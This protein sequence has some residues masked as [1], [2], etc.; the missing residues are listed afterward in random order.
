MSQSIIR[1]TVIICTA[2]LIVNSLSAQNQIYF[3]DSPLLLRQSIDLIQKEQ[4]GAALQKIERLKN[5]IS[6]QNSPFYADASYYEALCAVQL[7][8]KDAIEKVTEFASMHRSSSWMPRMNFLEGRVFFE[9]KRYNDALAAFTK[10]NLNALPE[11]EQVELEYKMAFCLL[12]QNQLKEAL[13]RF[14]KIKETK[15]PYQNASIYHYAH[16]QYLNSKDDDA[17]YHFQRIKNIS[18]FKKLVPLYELQ[19]NYR[20]GN[21][22]Q[23]MLKGNEV[24]QQVESKRKTEVLRMIADAYYKKDLF[25]KALSYYIQY[26]NQNKRQ[27][28]R[29]DNYQIGISRYKTG[30][31]KEAIQN[32][33]LVINESDALSQSASYHLAQCFLKNNQKPFAR[34]AFLAAHKATFDKQISEDAL[35]NY[36][37]LS[38][39][40][41]S[42]PFHDAAVLLEKYI[43]SRINTAR[44]NEAQQLI[45]QHYLHTNNFDAALSSLEKNKSRNHEM[46]SI[47]EQ[48]TY[49]LAIELYNQGNFAKATTYLKRLQ[50][51]NTN[52]PLHAN[53][54]FWLAESYYQQKNFVDAQTTY[55]QFIANRVAPKSEYFQL[56]TY[57]LGYTYFQLKQYSA[58]VPSFKQF[59]ANTYSKDPRLTFDAWM[60]IGDC[61]FI[62]KEFDKAIDAYEKVI[63]ARHADA[64]Y[65]LFQKGIAMGA[66]G[67]NNL[68]I[69]ALDQLIKNYPR[70]GFY[71]N[72]LFEMAT[73]NIIMND[74]R[75]AIAFFDQLARE[76][77]RSPFAKEALLKTGLIYFNNNQNEA[78]ITALKKVA[79]TYPGTPDAREALNTL[80]VIYMEINK[81]EEYFVYSKKMG[82]TQVSNSQQDS[83]SFAMAEK[84]YNEGRFQEANQ[85]V[86]NYLKTYPNG[87]YQL[88]AHR[89]KSKLSIRNKL[90]DEALTS[91][92][93]IISHNTNE[94]LE[95]ALL[96]A[97][98]I[99]YDKA[100]YINAVATYS[101]LV[102]LTDDPLQKLEALEGKM[103][104]N[105]FIGKY[106]EA[107][108]ASRMLRSTEK[109]SREQQMQA[110]YIAGKSLFELK[111]YTEAKE[112][113][114]KTKTMNNGV[115]GAEAYYLLAKI[116]FENN[117]LVDAEH[118]IFDLA[119]KFTKFDFW[120]AKSFLL[121]AD[122]YVKNN[123]VFQ[124]K[125]T[126]KSIIDNYKGDDLRQEAVRKL[127]ML[128]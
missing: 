30:L 118:Q 50:N 8:E 19:I 117:N 61:H 15:S 23:V 43:E 115:F 88:S 108:Q 44:I 27:H 90:S 51:T 109:V 96:D 64:D 69:A 24:L 25:D 84:F 72:A 67:K 122:I 119:D 80:R 92:Q 86:S 112:E 94:F 38:L 105:Y 47:Y 48:L 6:D 126:L 16:I 103:K 82:F 99:Y 29:E 101:R 60:R 91:L 74:F 31:F 1:K 2:F 106:Q 110:H 65:A 34:S 26:E 22:E 3:D 17:L 4:F 55:K 121:L 37:K 52:A 71:D 95:E 53:A 102:D 56:A 75:S 124:A 12:R 13:V 14:E 63:V 127:G 45:I 128:K 70:S 114:Q 33:Q 83:L 116:N 28:S 62:N 78:A 5:S 54:Q 87:A 18:Q 59:V 11:F 77:P 66:L 123:N 20:K 98:R 120:V 58:A 41:G 36:A 35:F 111:S 97:A 93:F 81:L 125:E 32:L 49:S 89:Y 46:Q 76:K 113:L 68:K 39:Q 40:I 57:N 10:V 100:D 21:Y 42:D 107:I 73:T 104:S 85:A 7:N 79:E 9:Q